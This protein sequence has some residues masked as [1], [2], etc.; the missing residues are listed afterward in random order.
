VGDDDSAGGSCVEEDPVSGGE[1]AGGWSTGW[2]S[3]WFV[4]NAQGYEQAKTVTATTMKTANNLRSGD[5][6]IISSVL[7]FYLIPFI[8]IS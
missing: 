5:V 8:R 4:V 3:D 2:S 7:I 6:F 1:S